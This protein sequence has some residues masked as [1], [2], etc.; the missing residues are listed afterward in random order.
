MTPELTQKIRGLSAAL[1]FFEKTLRYIII[2]ISSVG[3]CFYWNI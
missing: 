2:A 3:L 1:N